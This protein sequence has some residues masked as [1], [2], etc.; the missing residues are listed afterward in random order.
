MIPYNDIWRD[1]AGEAAQ[2][3]LVWN[4]NPA[5]ALDRLVSVLVSSMAAAAVREGA[6]EVV[7]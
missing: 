2:A 5:L 7:P 3:V 6:R 1:G 4:Q